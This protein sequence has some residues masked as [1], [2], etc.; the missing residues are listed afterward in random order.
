M[1]GRC[2]TSRIA[3]IMKPLLF[4]TPRHLISTEYRATQDS[5]QRTWS[6]GDGRTEPINC[7]SSSADNI[8]VTTLAVEFI[9]ASMMHDSALLSGISFV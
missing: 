2:L 7:C 1:Y 8:T 3:R 6:T 9:Y 4:M 5:C